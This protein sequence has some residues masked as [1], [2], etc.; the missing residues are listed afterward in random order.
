MPQ[1]KQQI[2]LYTLDGEVSLDV[3]VLDEEAWV[4]Q[5][6]IAMLFNKSRQLISWH[7]QNILKE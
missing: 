5:E 3:L 1:E 6:Q 4:N 2:I 7:I